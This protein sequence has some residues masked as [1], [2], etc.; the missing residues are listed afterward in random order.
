MS[1][2]DRVSL[3]LPVP[4]DIGARRTFFARDQRGM[5]KTEFLSQ[6][7]A[8]HPPA[9]KRPAT[10]MEVLR[11]YDAGGKLKLLRLPPGYRLSL[12]A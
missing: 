5:P 1:Q 12:E 2:V 8:D 10:P 7:I 4:I 11:T 6:L 3:N 9:A